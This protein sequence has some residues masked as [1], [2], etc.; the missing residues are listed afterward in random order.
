MM[1]PSLPESAVQFLNWTWPQIEPYFQDLYHR[2]VNQ[3]NILEWLFDWSEL[4]K[5]LDESYWRLYDATT[6]DTNNAEGEKKFKHF[7][8][9]VRPQAKAG[10]QKL[11]KKL[12]D[13]GITP[14]GYEVPLRNLSTQADLFREVNLALLSEDRKL[15]VEFD[16]IIGAQT[17]LWEGKEVALPQ[18][19]P[20]F[21][22]PDRERREKAWRLAA[23]RQLAD[24]EALNDLWVRFLKLRQNIAAN[25]DLPDFRAYRWRELLRF[26]YSP[27]DCYQFHQA[28]AE[29]VVPA[30]EK[31]YEKRRQIMGVET[32]RPWDL[33]VDP[34]GKPPLTPFSDIRELESKATQ[35]FRQV[36]PELSDYFKI[37]RDEGLLDLDN[38]INKAPGGYCNF[39]MYSRRPFIFMNAVGIH[40]D[41]QTILHEGGHAFNV[42]E[43]AHL[44]YF[45]LEVPLE[46]A[47]VA[48]MS[49]ELLA[50][51]YLVTELGGF[52]NQGDAARARIQFLERM[53]L[54]WPYMAVVDG[55]Q[56]WVY[57]NEQAALNPG[58]CDA[59]WAQLWERFMPGVDWSGL[60]QEKRTGWQRKPH[61]F[62]D[63]FYYVEYGLAQLGAVQ[64]WRNSL[65]DQASA[66]AAYRQALSL[67]TSV[68]L[69]KLYSTAGAKFTFDATTLRQSADLI[70]ET[71]SDLERKIK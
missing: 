12:L 59:C 64:V 44:P 37:M 54:F 63:P 31:V 19:L 52:Y 56:H 32:L 21:E 46:F 17:V 22:H 2:S 34:F 3:G 60:E 28:I 40:D 10:E 43:C 67:G 50:G 26:D 47:E 15:V 1:K 35:I 70:L 41:V 53:L 18:L 65:K 42:F 5:L 7:L 8:D 9:E 66:V 68:T 57:E 38:R 13:S 51:P 39:Y 6:I 45:F 62:D 61:I 36:D 11:K 30:A 16:K 23:E 29:V 20:E 14:K 33:D 4:S 58:N 24:R 48:S 27:E 71:I 55:F 49:M 69:S 25:A